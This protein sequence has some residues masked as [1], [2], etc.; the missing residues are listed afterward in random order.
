M[1]AIEGSCWPLDRM[2]AQRRDA[3]FLGALREA[4][5]TRFLLLVGDRFAI[6]S[7][8]ARD[9]ARLRLLSRAQLR[10]F[11][12]DA[13]DALFLG[14]NPQSGT[15]LFALA[16]KEHEV[17]E[18]L[19]G[20][21]QPL[22]DLRSIAARGAMPADEVAAAS[23]A[24]S[25][26]AWHQT[27][28]CCGRCGAATRSEEGGWKRTCRACGQPAFPRLDPVAIMLV[29]DGERCVLAR[30]PRFP[31]RMYSTIAGFIEPGEDLEQAVRRETREEI[32]LDVARVTYLATQPWPFPH[33]FM[34]G[35]L[36][37]AVAAPLALDPLEIDDARWFAR[38][39]VA[40]MLR[41]DHPEGLWLPGRH[42]IAHTLVRH[43]AESRD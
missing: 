20:L 4:A 42:A 18:P 28:R 19:A 2:S 10:G 9:F 11:A 37:E 16:L 33:S 31:E 12:L 23:T 39:E 40:L 6:V 13:R 14:C 26:A 38:S 30:E 17:D 24:K 36:A 34:I 29:H 22:V 27:V 35:C 43:W 5:S 25:L 7:N 41:G 15:G 21:L 3:A 1:N 8:E 32:G